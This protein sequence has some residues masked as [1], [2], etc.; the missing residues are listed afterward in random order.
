MKFHLSYKS[1][2]V[3]RTFKRVGRAR[4]SLKFWYQK[5]CASKALRIALCSVV[6]ALG[7]GYSIVISNVATKG[8]ELS[9]VERD[10]AEL[11]EANQKIRLSIAGYRSLSTVQKRMEILGMVPVDSV[12]YVAVGGSSVAAR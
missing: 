11:R 12:T 7:V 4:H 8:Y 6:V 9:D 1:S 3:K 10:I 2:S 5:A